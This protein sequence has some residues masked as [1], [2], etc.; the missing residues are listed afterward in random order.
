MK[1]ASAR[2]PLA[3]GSGGG[4]CGFCPESLSQAGSTSGARTRGLRANQASSTST[5]LFHRA[6]AGAPPGPFALSR[7]TA[8][9][10]A[11]RFGPIHHRAGATTG[12]GSC[13]NG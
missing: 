5:P 9:G 3:L 1:D 2:I 7:P 11:D 4:A 13:A 10:T 6:Y 12:Q 8:N